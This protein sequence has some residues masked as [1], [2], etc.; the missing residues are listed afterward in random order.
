MNNRVIKIFFNVLGVTASVLLAAFLVFVYVLPQ[1][2]GPVIEEQSPS[3]A[4]GDIS[5][6]SD[7]IVFDGTGILDLM[8]GVYAD[9]GNGNDITSEVTAVITAEGTTS[10]KIVSY[11][12]ID[13]NGNTLSAKR[14][15]IMEGYVGP[16]IVINSPLSL[17]AENL[18]S[19]ISYLQS[20]NLLV[21]YDGFG[22]NITADVSYQREKIADENYKFTFRVT[23]GYGDEKTVS[24][25]GTII[26]D[27]NDPDF[28]LYSDSVTVKADSVFEPLKYVVSQTPSVGRIVADN[29]V[30]TTVPGEYRVTYT[31]YSTD[32][33]ARTTKIM[34]VTVK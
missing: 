7:E 25:N 18:G 17:D 4:Q 24:V 22:K 2:Y 31:A 28:E 1:D 33:T 29:S 21:A 32:N 11:S 27:V 26:G 14:V 8:A 30:D 19:L 23:N 3:E 16:S 12:C 5:F 20:E 10:R 9:D 6:M 13:A 34:N 15:L